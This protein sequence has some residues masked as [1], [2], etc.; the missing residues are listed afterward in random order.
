M[1]IK[2]ASNK[3]RCRKVVSVVVEVSNTVLP[4]WALL[5]SVLLPV[6]YVLPS[7]FIFVM[8]G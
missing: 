3:E 7:G 8:T 6:L 4:L 1:N 2:V 5:I